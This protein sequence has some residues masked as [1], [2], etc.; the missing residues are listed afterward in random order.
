[1]AADIIAFARGFHNFSDYSTYKSEEEVRSAGIL[2][3]NRFKKPNN[4]SQYAPL[5]RQETAGTETETTGNNTTEKRI[6]TIVCPSRDLS[7]PV[8]LVKE[9]GVDTITA[10]FGQFNNSDLLKSAAK[11]IDL[12]DSETIW[13]D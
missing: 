8:S 5:T 1:M 3:L 13:R 2:S 7:Y 6:V 10:D 4:T 9:M 11:W 12:S